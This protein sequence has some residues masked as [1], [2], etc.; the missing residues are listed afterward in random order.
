[1]TAAK[2]DHSDAYKYWDNVEQADLELANVYDSDAGT[3]GA[4]A[5]FGVTVKR[6]NVSAN[7][8]EF[9]R[10]QTISDVTIFLVPAAL[11][12]HATDSIEDGSTITVGTETWQV[13]GRGQPVRNGS[14][15]M[16]HRCTCVLQRG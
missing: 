10:F 3:Y 1:M 11:I 15:V 16:H 6:V 8:P 5:L 7:S 2:I 12:S 14:V 9:E 13:Q 4:E